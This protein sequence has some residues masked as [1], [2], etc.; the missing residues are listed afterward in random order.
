ML[1]V[2]PS[3]PLPSLAGTALRP[4]PAALE[5]PARRAAGLATPAFAR[6]SSLES[7]WNK[8]SYTPSL[9]EELEPEFAL[10]NGKR[11]YISVGALFQPVIAAVTGH[12]VDSGKINACKLVKLSKIIQQLGSSDLEGRLVV[13]KPPQVWITPNMLIPSWRE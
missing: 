7:S 2:S 8:K 9:G 1:S 11:V 10:R 6:L 13:G 3:L 4:P 12:V 5:A